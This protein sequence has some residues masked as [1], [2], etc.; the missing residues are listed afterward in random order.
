MVLRVGLGR[1]DVMSPVLDMLIMKLYRTTKQSSGLE[2]SCPS[3][4]QNILFIVE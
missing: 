2:V 3:L 4:K 1:E